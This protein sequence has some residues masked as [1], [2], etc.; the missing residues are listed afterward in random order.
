VV[1][2]EIDMQELRSVIGPT[3]FGCRI[4]HVIALKP[5]IDRM[6]P[7]DPRRRAIFPTAAAE[8]S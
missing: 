6:L 4:G 3:V 7:V 2:A 1:Q 8:V 5:A